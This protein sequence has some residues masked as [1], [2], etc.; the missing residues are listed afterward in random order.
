[1]NN[2]EKAEKLLKEIATLIKEQES[3]PAIL[4][5]DR[6][7]QF[8]ETYRLVL[9]FFEGTNA[10]IKYSLHK[11]FITTGS[12]SVVADAVTIYD[13]DV[14]A[15]M[16]RFANNVDFYARTDGRICMDLAFDGIAYHVEP[17]KDE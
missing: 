13:V 1:M 6:M 16:V 14:F 12:I 10:K 3:K 15:K 2:S 8:A 4:D 5:T 17:K 11:P 7:A 9:D